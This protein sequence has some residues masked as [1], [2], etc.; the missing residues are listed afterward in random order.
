M[1]RSQDPEN[2]FNMA[3]V[4]GAKIMGLEYGIR[5]GCAADMM[6]LDA[7]DY[8]MALNGAA[9]I[10]YVFSKGRLVCSSKTEVDYV[11]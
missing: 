3:S 6:V 11:R 9:S 8:R 1:T 5:P 4:N 10:A 2:L 7:K